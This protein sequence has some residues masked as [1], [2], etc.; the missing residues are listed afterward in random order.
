MSICASGTKS[1][2]KR[3]K[4]RQ[5]TYSYN[6]RYKDDVNLAIDPSE[7]VSIP[8][9]DDIS[10]MKRMKELADSIDPSLTVS[11][12]CCSNHIDGKTPVL[13]IRVWTQYI[14]GKGWKILHCHYIKEVP[15]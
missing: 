10:V 6:R 9:K 11:T 13:D 8:V 15:T 4:N 5:L 12:D 14:D 3:V 1:C 7:A 2:S